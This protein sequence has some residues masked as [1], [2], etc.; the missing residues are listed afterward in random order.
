MPVPSLLAAD[1]FEEQGFDSTPWNQ[2][3]GAM[4]RP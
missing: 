2:K 1:I 4:V 3:F